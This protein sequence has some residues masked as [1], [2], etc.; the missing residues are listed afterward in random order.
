MRVCVVF[1]PSARGARARRFYTALQRLSPAC[2]LCPT[3]HPGHAIELAARAAREGF[4]T[5]VAAGGDGTLS[6]VVTGLAGVPG[7]LEA[8]RLGVIPLGTSNVFARELGLPLRPRAAWQVILAGAE[9]RVD[10]PGLEWGPPEQRHTR[11]FVQLAGAGLDSRAIARVHW[12]AKQR[13]GPL[14][15][16]LAGLQALLGAQPP[17]TLSAGGARWSGELALLGNGRFY[18]GSVPVFPAARN[19]DGLLDAVVFPR[20]TWLTLTR[21]AWAWLTGR[22]LRAPGTQT[23]RAERLEVTCPEPLPIE[24]DGDNVGV[25]PG[26]FTVRP[27]AL[28]VL[29]LA[30]DPGGPV[31]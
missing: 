7:A 20:V 21:F 16:G 25:T 19:D 2:T 15:Y 4:A 26:V 23:L 9:R 1:N 14:A 30:P 10:L 13:V 27:R 3:H 29:A 6:E 22:P 31:A 8:V 17:V 18:G 28:R 11:R 24:V 12:G 5:L